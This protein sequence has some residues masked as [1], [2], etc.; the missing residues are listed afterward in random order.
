MS[1]YVW[2]KA[3]ILRLARGYPKEFLRYLLHSSPNVYRNFGFTVAH[4]RDMSG[5]P[6]QSVTIS[7]AESA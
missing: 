6:S 1:I 2:V 7:G 5:A 3:S 4:H